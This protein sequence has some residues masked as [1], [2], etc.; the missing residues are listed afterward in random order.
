MKDHFRVELSLPTL[1]YGETHLGFNFN[2]TATSSEIYL[3]TDA[4]NWSRHRTFFDLYCPQNSVRNGNN[5][6]NVSITPHLSDVIGIKLPSEYELIGCNKLKIWKTEVLE[7]EI[8]TQIYVDPIFLLST[9]LLPIGDWPDW[10]I[11]DRS[12]QNIY[13]G[14]LL[15]E[16]KI[17]FTEN[18]YGI[19]NSFFDVLH[20]SG[21]VEFNLEL[22]NGSAQNTLQV[23][24]TRIS[25]PR[26][27][28]QRKLITNLQMSL[29][30]SNDTFT[31]KVIMGKDDIDDER[32][33]KV[34]DG[35]FFNTGIVRASK[36]VIQ[37]MIPRYLKS[38][39][40]TLSNTAYQNI[41]QSNVADALQTIARKNTKWFDYSS[42]DN[43]QD[44]SDY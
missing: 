10:Y 37:Q 17:V 42:Y 36:Y 39:S 33:D 28:N 5:S 38:K 7:N 30:S 11:N 29:D 12:Y 18:G 4:S 31:A 8:I 6:A 40:F 32:E 24:G 20:G 2:T 1:F 19:K 44:S 9:S 23:M 3:D 21:G 43:Y 27:R 13:K 14:L 22:Q 25:F 35:K 26:L 16:E 34:I 15:R 41:L